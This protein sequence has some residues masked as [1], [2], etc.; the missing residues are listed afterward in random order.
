MCRCLYE[1]LVMFLCLCFVDIMLKCLEKY[2]FCRYRI[3]NK[4]LFWFSCVLLFVNFS[5]FQ[6]GS[7]PC[8]CWNSQKKIHFVGAIFFHKGLMDAITKYIQ[9]NLGLTNYWQHVVKLVMSETTYRWYE[10]ALANIFF[11]RW[12]K[13]IKI[14][15]VYYS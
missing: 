5:M 6:V 15:D 9:H 10:K 7:T 13:L 8:V 14:V 4:V 12:M 1:F 11:H 2:S 3:L